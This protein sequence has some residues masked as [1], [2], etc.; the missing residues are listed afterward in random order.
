M[1]ITP[2][3]VLAAIQAHP[4]KTAQELGD[5][6]GASETFVRRTAL[7]LRNEGVV[8]IVIGQRPQRKMAGLLG[9]SARTLPDSDPRSWTFKSCH[10]FYPAEAA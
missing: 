2:A 7:V 5:L 4:G 1:N 9:T 3:I 6:I 8:R 10:E